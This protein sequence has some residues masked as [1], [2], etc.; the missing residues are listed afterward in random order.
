VSDGTDRG[1]EH[2]GAPTPADWDAAVAAIREAGNIVVSCH[3]NPDG[4]AIGSALALTLALNKAGRT[5]VAS[6]SQPFVIAPA[7][8]FLDGLDGLVPPEQVPADADLF[9]CFDTGSIDRLGTLQPAFESAKRSLVVDHHASNAGFGDL[10][11]VDPAAPASAVLCRELLAR[12]D[13]PLDKAIATCL[14]VGLV[15]DTGRFQY[16]A[17]KPETH[18]LAAELLAAGVEQYEISRSIFET[19]PIGYLRLLATV[20]GKVAQVPEAS[21][22]WTSVTRDDLA[23]ADIDLEETEG[24][25]DV[26]RIDGASD[27]AAVFKEQPGGGWKASLRSKGGT[28]VGSIA[29]GLGG[30]GHRYAAGFTSS[31][32]LDATVKGLVERLR[33]TA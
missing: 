28:D 21:L 22:I 10:S 4:D 33:G 24:L 18:L 16:Q 23:A 15:T 2:A 5:A 9:V 12:L 7:Y 14:Y 8:R 19:A 25:I 29:S 1:A 32:D 20:V 11:L 26:V 3:V 31:L 6:F 27:V 30:G 13:L 17:T